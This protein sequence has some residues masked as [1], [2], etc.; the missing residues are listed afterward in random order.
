M[1]KGVTAAALAVCALLAPG[2]NLWTLGER[3]KRMGWALTSPDGS[4]TLRLGGDAPRDLAGGVANLVASL[5]AGGHSLVSGK[6]PV[7]LVDASVVVGGKT[8][9]I[10]EVRIGKAFLLGDDGVTSFRANNVSAVGAFAFCRA[11][12]LGEVSLEGSADALPDGSYATHSSIRKGVFSDCPALTNLTLALPVAYIG[13]AAFVG[14]TNL[15]SDVGRLFS[16]A[17][18]N[19]GACAFAECGRLRGVFSTSAARAVGARAFSESGIEDIRLGCAECVR[20]LPGGVSSGRCAY[21]VFTPMAALTNLE[22][23]GS[24]LVSMGSCNIGHAPRLRTLAV[25]APKLVSLGGSRACCRG[26]TALE[27]IDLETPSLRQVGDSWPPFRDA[28]AVRE[29]IWRGSPPPFSVLG[30]ILRGVRPIPNTAQEGKRCILRV[31]ADDESWAGLISPFELGEQAYAPPSCDGVL[32]ASSR[33]AW[34]MRDAP[35]GR[36]SSAAPE[37][38]FH[39]IGGNASKEG[40]LADIAALADAGVSGIQFF[41]GGWAKDEPWPGVTDM[42]P[43][44]SGK[45]LDLVKTAEEECH[46]R[47]LSFKMQNCPGWSMSG[48]PWIT[49][50]RAMRKLVC[51]RPG[52]KP[53]FGPDDDYHEIGEV[54][55]AAEREDES[56]ARSVVLPAPSRLNH[57][58]CYEPDIVFEV[59]SGGRKALER[60]CPQGTY[61]DTFSADGGEMT[62]DIGALPREGLELRMRTARETKPFSPVWSPARRLDNWQAKSGWTLRGFEMSTDARP[63]SN[64]VSRTLVFGHVNM[65]RRNHPAPPEATGW[66]CDKMDPRGFEANFA[67]YMGRVVGAG[68][69]VDGL[70]VDS[71]ECGCQTWTWKMEEEFERRAGYALRPWLPALFG[72]VLKSESETERFLLDWRNVSSRLVEEN[73]YAAISRT[74][75]AHGMTVQYE[76]ACGDVIPGDILRYWKYAD[77]PMC[78]FW[79]PHRNDGFVGS[80]DF[81]P[82]LPCVSAAHIYGKRRVSAE[83]LTSFELTFDENFRDWKRILDEHLARGVTHIVFHTYTHN[84]VTGGKPPSTS[85]GAGIGSPFLREQTW[86]P[87]LKHLTKYLE[88]C[89]QELERGLPAVDMLMYL[90]D[91]V[92]HKPS[93]SE[94]LFGNRYKYDYLNGDVLMTSLGVKGGRFVLPDGMDY[95]VLW[96]PKGTFLLPETEERLAQLEKEGGRVVRGDFVPDWESPL[97]ERLGREAS[98]VLGWYQRR[99]GDV[100]IFFVAEKDGRSAFYRVCGASCTVFDPV[101]GRVCD[102]G[103]RAVAGRRG[104]SAALPVALKPVEDYPAWAVRRVYEGVVEIPADAVEPRL[105]LGAVRDWATVFVDGRKV[106][107]LWCSPYACDMPLPVTAGKRAEVRVE[108]VSTWYNALVRDARLPEEE[109]TTWTKNGPGAD[110]DYHESGLLGPVVV[111]F[112]RR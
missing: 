51:F 80:F 27:V 91:D 79:S 102:V 49:P 88:R 3:D 74:A 61:A 87:Y 45:W 99:D 101:T 25:A 31:P 26:L 73:Y 17:V 41:H 7:D 14:C 48:G 18:T 72:Y 21:G 112:S 50:D 44:L 55:F 85:F 39:V 82:V 30:R 63:L 89:G 93:E 66:E 78:E 28:R 2:E 69:K 52:E 34:V 9:P 47:G 76:T 43:C 62:F 70:L 103:S 106:A 81:K 20:E 53:A 58:W 24:G 100:D 109:R 35:Q 64:T 98:D 36:R 6:G 23:R 11:G 68:V 13:S 46:R 33:K 57:H 94:L 37:T 8:L 40:L 15:S 108:V 10:R 42:I 77:E 29:V 22:V 38:W 90:G 5:N 54:V 12:A 65:K 4:V 56:V 83:A 84:P 97:K 92:N 110:A 19:V 96:V 75:H 71:W 67:G 16:D 95:R 111:S 32:F 104:A 1:V 59:W 86:W 107:D 60:R 105:D